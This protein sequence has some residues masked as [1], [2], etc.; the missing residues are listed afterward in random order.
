MT[1]KFPVSI[2]AVGLAVLLS[3]CAKPSP[4]SITVWTY[5][6]DEVIEPLLQAF[7]AKTGIP[8]EYEVLGGDGVVEALMAGPESPP[9]LVLAVDVLRLDQLKR[10]GLLRPLPERVTADVPGSLHDPEMH[11]TGISWRARAIF[12]RTDD[13][14]AADFSGLAELARSNQLCVRQGAHVYNRGLLAWLIGRW[15]ED[16][17]LRWAEAVFDQRRAI[18]GGDRDQIRAVA[19]GQCSVAIVNHYYALRF[20][21]SEDPAERALMDGMSFGWSEPESPVMANISGIALPVGSANP[22]GGERLAEWL[23]SLDGQQRYASSVFEFPAAWPD[24]DM[25]LAPGLEQ[26]E[27]RIAEP[28]PSELAGFRAPAESWFEARDGD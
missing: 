2:S 1:A 8:V 3:A 16:E 24:K 12:R 27:I 9:D 19:D 23:A 18:D 17:A 10:A 15:G 5:R 21:H 20:A 26:L 4:E 22:A 25:V 13:P 28:W 7:S 14:S 6:G 11:W